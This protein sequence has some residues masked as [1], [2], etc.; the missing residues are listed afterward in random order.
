MKNLY[1]ITKQDAF[2]EYC[3]IL[4]RKELGCERKNVMSVPQRSL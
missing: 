2:L 3:G 4:A 1:R